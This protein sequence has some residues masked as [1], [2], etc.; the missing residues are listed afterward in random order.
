VVHTGQLFF[1]AAISNAV[2]R[3][4]PY[5]AHGTEPD[6]SNPADSIFRNG[7][8]KGMLKLR[9]SGAGYLGSIVMG[10]QVA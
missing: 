2:Y 10:V 4:S 1:P 6:T 8:S 3:T 5:S 9:R 7:G